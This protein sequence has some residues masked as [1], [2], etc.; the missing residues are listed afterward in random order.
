MENVMK[1]KIKKIIIFCRR[2]QSNLNNFNS[3][4]KINSLQI[5]ITQLQ[6]LYR[7]YKTCLNMKL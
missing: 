1:I 6:K 4:V 5:I 3:E 7:L 2:Q